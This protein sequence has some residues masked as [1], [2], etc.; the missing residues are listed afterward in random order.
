MLLFVALLGVGLAIAGESYSLASR[1][2]RERE[3]LFV[4]GQFRDALRSYYLTQMRAGKR[5]YPPSLEELLADSRFPGVR[6]HL[7]KVYVDPMTGKAEWGLVTLAGGI[8]GVHSLSD[9][10]PLKQANFEP[11]DAE[12]EGRSKYSEWVFSYTPGLQEESQPQPPP[13]VTMPG[14]LP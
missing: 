7:R 4:G 14:D 2:D 8:V 11:A 9:A 6:R 12:L 5:E 1:R 10:K 3:L 13:A